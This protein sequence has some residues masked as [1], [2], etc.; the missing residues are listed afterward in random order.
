MVKKGPFTFDT[1]VSGSWRDGWRY[2]RSDCSWDHSIAP[3]CF[4]HPVHSLIFWRRYSSFSVLF[5]YL[6]EASLRVTAEDKL[7]YMAFETE[8]TRRKELWNVTMWDTDLRRQFS[9]ANN[10]WE[11]WETFNLF[12]TKGRYQLIAKRLDWQ[13]IF[14][15]IRSFHFFQRYRTCIDFILPVGPVLAPHKQQ[16]FELG[17]RLRSKQIMSDFIETR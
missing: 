9:M 14:Q 11:K 8:T 1:L 10:G 15:D 13:T 3:R 4:G 6:A 12:A 7:K 17:K 5:S 2:P 16:T